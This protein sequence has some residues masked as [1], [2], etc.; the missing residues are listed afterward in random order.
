LD[1]VL[2]GGAVAYPK[3]QKRE[4]KR[5]FVNFAKIVSILSDNETSSGAVQN[6]IDWGS[7]KV[8][9]RTVNCRNTRVYIE[10]RAISL[11]S[12]FI[13]HDNL[14]ELYMKDETETRAQFLNRVKKYLKEDS[15]KEKLIKV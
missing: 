4:Y 3:E 6:Q 1:L 11:Q 8:Q 15:E 2:S 14:P 9:R 13:Q 12:G 5:F 7:E 10:N